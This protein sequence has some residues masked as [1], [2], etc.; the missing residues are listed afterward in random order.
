M[1]S[2]LTRITRVSLINPTRLAIRARHNTN[3][4]KD[5]KGS[6]KTTDELGIPLEPTWSVNELLSSYPKPAISTTTLQHLHRLSALIPPEQGSREHAELTMQ[7]EDLVKL[8]EAVKQ[9]ELS[10][11]TSEK[12]TTVPDGRIWAEGMGIP[13]DD[14]GREDQDADHDPCGPALLR[15]ASR[16]AGGLY[17]VEATRAKR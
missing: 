10:P 12:S 8:V 5:Y 15:H 6:L 14:S 2:Q 4:A 1:L 13:L 17:V 7:M 9:A 16:T 11:D 3:F